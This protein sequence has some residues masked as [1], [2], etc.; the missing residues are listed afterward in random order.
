MKTPSAT[1]AEAVEPIA[2]RDDKIGA[3]DVELAA[4]TARGWGKAVECVEHERGAGGDDQARGVLGKPRH[5]RGFGG[6]Q[7]GEVAAL[8]LAMSISE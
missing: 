3:G 5:R 7:R 6:G 1:S 4:E 8:P 2:G